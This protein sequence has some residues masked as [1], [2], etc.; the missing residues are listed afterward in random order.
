[1]N[2]KDI[3]KMSKLVKIN[4]SNNVTKPKIGQKYKNNGTCLVIQFVAPNTTESALKS[5]VEYC[6]DCDIFNKT[7]HRVSADGDVK[8]QIYRY[9]FMSFPSTSTA[10]SA[11]CTLDNRKVDGSILRVSDKKSREELQAQR[12]AER[13][14]RRQKY[15]EF[16]RQQWKAQMKAQRQEEYE[17]Q[18]VQREQQRK[19]QMIED[20]ADKEYYEKKQKERQQRN[21]FRALL[22]FRNSDWN[23][24]KCSTINFVPRTVC[25]KCKAD[26]I[27]PKEV[28]E[29]E[30]KN[31]QMKRE[32]REK[33]RTTA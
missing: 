26:R 14:Q 5:L 28:L 18:K 13:E 33:E 10:F 20:Q 22:N 29:A 1:M 19:E 24:S 2:Q 31:E 21:A 3:L 15:H 11:K 25:F 6:I 7:I 17:Q 8:E 30:K 9:A 16:R 32:K 27:I 23:C 4:A 12:E